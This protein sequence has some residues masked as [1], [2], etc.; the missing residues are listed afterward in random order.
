M[1]KGNSWLFA[2]IQF[3]NSIYFQKFDCISYLN[4]LE[5]AFVSRIQVNLQSL[6]DIWYQVEKLKSMSK[7]SW[8]FDTHLTSSNES[9]IPNWCQ[10]IPLSTLWISKFPIGDLEKKVHSYKSIFLQI[11]IPIDS[12][13]GLISAFICTHYQI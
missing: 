13:I 4:V 7:P 2:Q 10:S 3:R 6:L 1:F 5:I 9:P 11:H 8:T 12:M